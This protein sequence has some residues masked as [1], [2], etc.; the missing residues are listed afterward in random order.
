MLVMEPS[1]HPP[2]GAVAVGSSCSMKGA[3]VRWS[4]GRRL[5]SRYACYAMP[6]VNHTVCYRCE[7]TNAAVPSAQDIDASREGRQAS[8]PPIGRPIPHIS[9][10]RVDA[11]AIAAAWKAHSASMWCQRCRGGL[12]RRLIVRRRGG[13]C[14]GGRCQE[15][16]QQGEALNL[17]RHTHRGKQRSE[18]GQRG[19]VMNNRMN[20]WQTPAA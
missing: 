16:D 15:E 5:W 12:T 2:A 20:R 3:G 7:R 8:M 4:G 6:A 1:S 18:R 10:T 14:Q 9:G 17:H 19:G 11:K 13:L